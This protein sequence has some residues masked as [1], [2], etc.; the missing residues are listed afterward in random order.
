VEQLLSLAAETGGALGHDS[1]ALGKSDL[2][3]E[4]R[5]AALAELALVALGDVESDDMVA[6]LEVGHALADAL[7]DAGALMS[8]HHWE[9]ALRI[10]TAQGEGIRV[11]DARGR[12]LDAHLLKSC[13][14]GN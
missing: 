12:D 3:A 1:S 2:L 6:S 4:I 10:G 11:A 13:H 9:Q 8:Q 7:H 5:L 14:N